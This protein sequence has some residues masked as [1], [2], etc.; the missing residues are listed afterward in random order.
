MISFDTLWDAQFS[1][2]LERG[3]HPQFF[4]SDLRV[5]A[6]SPAMQRRNQSFRLQA[7]RLPLGMEI[8][9][10]DAVAPCSTRESFDCPGT[11][12]DFDNKE[13]FAGR[14]VPSWRAEG[15]AMKGRPSFPQS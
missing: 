5:T 14:N 1:A 3:L 11:D 6:P 15:F 13:S 12:K 7:Q 10:R 9:S 8:A 2:F 4:V